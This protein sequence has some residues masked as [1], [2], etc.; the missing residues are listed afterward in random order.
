MISFSPAVSASPGEL[1]RNQP[2]LLA[3]APA[4]ARDREGFQ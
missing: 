1:A 3:S 2:E 4:S